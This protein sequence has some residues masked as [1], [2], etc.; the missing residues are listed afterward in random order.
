MPWPV[1][2]GCQRLALSASLA[3][4]S[5]RPGQA[6]RPRL[7]GN[8]LVSWASAPGELVLDVSL[9]F[10][11]SGRVEAVEGHFATGAKSGAWP[12][13]LLLERVD[14]AQWVV[15]NVTQAELEQAGS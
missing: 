1:A 13:F 8:P 3:W 15:R 2:N 4:V 9:C 10:T 14:A 12:E 5:A 7:V 6:S 11:A